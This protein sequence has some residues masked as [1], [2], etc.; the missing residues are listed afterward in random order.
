MFLAPWRTDD[1]WSASPPRSMCRASSRSRA[2]WHASQISVPMK[3]F[4]PR[5][6]HSGQAPKGELKENSRGSISG[7]ENPS[8]GHENLEENNVSSPPIDTATSPSDSNNA[9]STA[10]DSRLSKFFW[11]LLKSDK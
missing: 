11:L 5:P 9:F 3:Y 6:W 2:P 7:N 8:F 10:S 4:V 1:A